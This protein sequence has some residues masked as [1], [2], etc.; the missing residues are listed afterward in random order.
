MRFVNSGVQLA[1]NAR[2]PERWR[3]GGDAGQN[4]GASPLRHR[5]AML[6]GASRARPRATCKPAPQAP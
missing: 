4:G 5:R 1:T 6:W 3:E 2:R